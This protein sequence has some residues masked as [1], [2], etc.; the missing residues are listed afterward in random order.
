MQD[1]SD[2]VGAGAGSVAV[3]E[4][5]GTSEEND[6]MSKKNGDGP[7]DVGNVVGRDAARAATGGED[8][9]QIPPPARSEGGQQQPSPGET[10][11]HR[12]FDADVSGASSLEFASAQLATTIDGV[13]EEGRALP[14]HT[15]STEKQQRP[16]GI[17]D[18]S[19]E[20]AHFQPE[21]GEREG[22]EGFASDGFGGEAEHTMLG[23]RSEFS[24]R[25]FQADAGESHGDMSTQNSGGINSAEDDDFGTR[26]QRMF[27]GSRVAEPDNVQIVDA[28][29][30]ADLIPGVDDLPIFANDQSKALND[31]IKVRTCSMYQVRRSRWEQVRMARWPYKKYVKYVLRY[32]GTRCPFTSCIT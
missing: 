15:I 26:S 29:D 18:D 13:K 5:A 9:N 17:M 19:H 21:E 6:M 27:D 7:D 22:D 31:E 8:A 11:A 16:G 28:G 1:E 25:G 24:G 4:A 14:F 2:G 3:D 30:G 20:S 32:M 10:H 12:G 23:G